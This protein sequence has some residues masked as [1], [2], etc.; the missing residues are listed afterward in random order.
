M[1]QKRDRL[2]I[3]SLKNES[4]LKTYKTKLSLG[5]EV[6]EPKTSSLVKPR[7]WNNFIVKFQN[8]KQIIIIE[9]TK[10]KLMWK[11]T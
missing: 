1:L 10:R 3:G 6:D 5:T 2:F 9:S 7:M 11:V 8:L 4:Q